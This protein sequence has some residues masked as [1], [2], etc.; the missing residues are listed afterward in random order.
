MRNGIKINLCQQIIFVV[1]GNCFAFSSCFLGK[2]KYLKHF[3][4]NS[5]SFTKKNRFFLFWI[6]IFSPI[7]RKYLH[8]LKIEKGPSYS[9]FPFLMKKFDYNSLP[10]EREPIQKA[11]GFWRL[12]YII[13]IS[14]RP[15][16]HKYYFSHNNLIKWEL[17]EVNVELN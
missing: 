2:K 9:Y 1:D 17:I 6:R 10:L 15:M 7:C 3:Y 13:E 5:F 11:L 8:A 16:P 14:L 4:S 12:Q